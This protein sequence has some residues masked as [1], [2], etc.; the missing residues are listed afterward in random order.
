[1]ASIGEMIGE[2]YRVENLIGE[3]SSATVY[4]VKDVFLSVY[5][6]LKEY[7]EGFADISDHE[8]E[9]LA[10]LNGTFFPK[11]Y[12]VISQNGQKYIVMELIEG[13]SL[14]EYILKEKPDDTMRN[15][16]LL[17]V[18]NNLI[19][20]HSRDNPVIYNDL[21]PANIVVCADGSV[22]FV[23]AASCVMC[24][25]ESNLLF[26]TD[27][28]S[29][30]NAKEGKADPGNDIYSLGM[31]MFYLYSGINPASFDKTIDKE[32]LRAMGIKGKR[33]DLICSCLKGCKDGCFKTA[34][35]V[36]ER[37]LEIFGN[38]S[39]GVNKMHIYSFIMDIWSIGGLSLGALGIYNYFWIDEREGEAVSVCALIVLLSLVLVFEVFNKRQTT[40]NF[41]FGESICLS[42]ARD[43]ILG[44]VVLLTIII[45][46]LA[47]SEQQFFAY[48]GKRENENTVSLVRSVNQNENLESVKY[49][50]INGGPLIKIKSEEDIKASRFEEG[51]NVDFYYK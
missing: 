35:D 27:C 16:I 42:D 49:C 13:I 21:K 15:R 30:D 4:R 29:N 46:S 19:I 14:E 9:I 8:A 17:S 48:T 28:Y 40:N 37:F 51:V 20:L 38:K 6:A 12:D 11:I 23:D 22:R 41:K 33:A 45:L 26:V 2:R 7:K 5:L 1:M 18:I 43:T 44:S 34:E 31:I 3:G 47:D 24:T 50:S 36:K 25:D 39:R 32:L 10:C